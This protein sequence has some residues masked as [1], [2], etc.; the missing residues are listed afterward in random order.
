MI[1][2]LQREIT[3]RQKHGP[4]HTWKGFIEAEG[5]LRLPWVPPPSV[6]H[7]ATRT[8]PSLSHKHV[9]LLAPSSPLW[10]SQ[11]QNKS[12]DLVTVLLACNLCVFSCC[13][14]LFM[15]LLQTDYHP[16][17]VTNPD[18]LSL[19][20]VRA[21]FLSLLSRRDVTVTGPVLSFSHEAVTEHRQKRYY[22]LNPSKI[23]TSLFLSNPQIWGSPCKQI[24]Y[25][26]FLV[27]FF[28]ACFLQVFNRCYQTGSCGELL[29]A[30]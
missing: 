12:L 21:R 14:H 17:L 22:F 9:S 8:F 2:G 16:T 24:H 6:S 30:P 18:V 3:R 23:K 10:F 29:P 20:C 1:P 4:N 19:T 26:C 11:R 15:P 27:F 28:L 5:S 13:L 7:R 25:L